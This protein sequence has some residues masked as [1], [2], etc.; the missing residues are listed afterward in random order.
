[1]LGGRA[2]RQTSGAPAHQ[3]T[4][5]TAE[6]SIIASAVQA[7]KLNI[8]RVDKL[9]SNL[10]EGQ[11]REE[12][13]PG[14]NRLI[15]LWGHLIAVHDAMFPL[16]GLGPRQYADLD[17]AFLTGADRAV[18]TLPC[19]AELKHMWND[20][21]GR[22]MTGFNAFTAADWAQKHTAVS[23]ADF[24]AN[25]LRNRLAVLLSRTAHVAYHHGQAVLA[26]GSPAGTA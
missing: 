24:A 3:E 12:V 15:Y 9:F 1:M 4:I 23:D 13:A 21:N 5:M 19:A 16:L 10:S 20:V 22:L 17:A 2:R 11:L 8:D 25:P 18:E 7:W 14:K 26:T 6:Q